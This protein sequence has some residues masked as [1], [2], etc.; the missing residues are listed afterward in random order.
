M[1]KISLLVMLL[2]TAQIIS[3]ED[4]EAEKVWRVNFINPSVEVDVPL[5]KS[6]VQSFALG[7]GYSASYPNLSSEFGPNGLVYVIAP[8]VDFQT[9]HFYN[10]RKREQ[11]EK[12]V[13]YNSGNFLSFRVFGRGNSLADNIER[14]SDYDFAIGPTWGLQRS[15]NQIHLLFDVGPQYYFDVEGN[16]GF[17]PVFLQLNVGF[18][19]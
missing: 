9:K 15:F 19:F 4:Y 3:Q 8:F 17:L 7:V 13:K 16:S 18:N 5:S 11:T 1:K 14:K 12:S 2:I 6:T 10:F